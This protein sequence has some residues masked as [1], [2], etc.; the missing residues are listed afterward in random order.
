MMEFDEIIINFAINIGAGLIPELINH[1]KSN[2]NLEDRINNAFQKA[3]NRWEV[4]QELRNLLHC[5]ALR[6]YS[7]LKDYLGDNQKARHPKTN[8]L[9][10][11]WVQEM[12]NDDLCMNF[13]AM[14]KLDISNCKLNEVLET[15]KIEIKNKLNDIQETTSRTWEKTKH[16]EEILTKLQGKDKEEIK[17]NL[18]N[19]LDGLIASLIEELKLDTAC[20]IINEI[21]RLFNPVINENKYLKAKLFF[22]KGETLLFSEPKKAVSLIHEAYELQPDEDDYI[23]WEVKKLIA[24]KDYAKAATIAKSFSEDDKCKALLSITT[25]DDVSKAFQDINKKLRSDLGFRQIALESLINK[26]MQNIDFLFEEITNTP[27]PKPSFST[28]NSWLFSI[29]LQ[30]NKIKNYLILAFDSPQTELFKSASQ[31]TSN[32]YNQLDKTEVSDRFPMVRC[33]HCYWTY[34]CTKNNS[35][36]TE[37]QKIDRKDFGEQK[38]IFSLMESSM[39]VLA[40]RYEE[41]FAVLVSTGQI[42]DDS[43]IHFAIKMSLLS[44]NTLYLRWVLGKMKADNIKVNSSNAFLIAMTIDQSRVRDIEDALINLDFEV[45]GE[46]ELLLQLCNHH[47]GKKI[48][49]EKFKSLTDTMS[50]EMKACAANLLANTGDTQLAF[51]MLS[52]IVEEGKDD[53]KQAVF[54]SVL[55]QMQ[56]KTPMLYHILVKNRKA[57]NLCNDQLLWQEYILDCAVADYDNASEAISELYQKNPENIDVFVNYLD[58]LGRLTPKE[59]SRYEEIAKS[60]NYPTVQSTALAYRAFAENDYLETAVE[61]LY[62]SANNSDDYVIRNYYQTEASSGFIRSIVHKEYD[63][64]EEGNYVLC[65]LDGKRLFYKASKNGGNIGKLLIG[66]QKGDEINVEISFYQTKLTVIEIHNKYAK[67]CGDILNE[68]FDGNNPGLQPFKIDMDNPLESLLNVVRKISKDD[69]S[70]E[71]K[72]RKAVEKYEQG[73]LGLLQLVSENNMLSGYYNLLF[74]PFTVHVN[75]AEIELSEINQVNEDTCFVLDLPTIIT[76][77]EFEAKMGLEIKGPKTIT[78]VLHEYLREA[79]KTSFRVV[80]SDFYN[81]MRSGMLKSYS[82]YADVDAIKHIK[83]LEEWADKRCEDIIADNALILYG[84]KDNSR[85]KNILFSSLSMLMKQGTYVVTDDKK[86][87]D[88]LPVTNI[89]STES[90]VNLFNNNATISAYSQFL[91]ESGFRGVDMEPLYIM[92]EYKK[93]ERQEDNKMLDIIQNIQENPFLLSKT[94]ACCILLAQAKIDLYTLKMTFTNMFVAAL[95]NFSLEFREN[96]VQNAIGYLSSSASAITFTLQCL[97]DAKKIAN[98]ETTSN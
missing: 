65:D 93:M 29:T 19:T 5:D 90:Y 37:Y 52:P 72:R 46:K 53:I 83:Y 82:K 96:I 28:I 66:A 56:E 27:L 12:R 30:R 49:I 9:L 87:K 70:P 71:E 95:K 97:L 44:N 61:I 7:D 58:I 78:K 63:V 13:I 51:D 22:Q 76:F 86:I 36:I 73:E 55:C 35:W 48:N 64:A 2:K 60:K 34:I 80:D 91:F 6:Y 77:A 17:E 88:W 10:K 54:L 85:Q 24:Q 40:K 84:S 79:N 3:L 15:I 23:K 26:G 62:K 81:S 39:L 16:I 38:V 1:I 47:A 18:L 75:V 21:E 67:L 59:L 33:L 31:L 8:E 68:A 43:I 74:T 45:E 42:L 92:E 20:K 14:H 4:S 69:I 50:N 32:F 25:A 89:I 11:L 57:G 94:I 41:A 98:A